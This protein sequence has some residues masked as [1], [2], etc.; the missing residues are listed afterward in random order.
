MIPYGR[1]LIE[2]D[3][4]EA[5]INVLRSDF[6]TQGPKIQEFEAEIA[7]CCNSKY[8]V[9]FNSGTS[10]L[11]AAYF[12]IGLKKRDNFITTP[13]TF[14]A[15][16]NAGL[17]LG[18]RPIFVDVESDTGNVDASRIEER[19]TENTK[20]IVPVHYAGHPANMEVIHNLAEKYDLFVVEDACHAL[21]SKYKQHK[22]GSPRYS[23]MTVLSFHPVKQI[24]TGE[25]GA[26]LTNDEKCYEKL[27]MFRAHGITKEKFLEKPHGDWYYE[28]Q[29]LGY[30]YR[31][32]DIQAALGLSQ[33][34]KLH[35]FI[36]RRR[37]IVKAYERAFDGNPYFDIPVEKGYAF[38]SYHLY[39]I[40]LKQEYASRK[41][42]IFS[43]MKERGLGVQVHYIPVYWQ[44]YYRQM[45]YKMGICPNAEEF[46]R[47]EIS[48][49]LHQSMQD[50][51][52]EFIVDSIL[53]IFRETT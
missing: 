24:T 42:Q 23:D 38:S 22:I 35:R 16:S 43:K 20:L 34:R 25:G 17:Y 51:D 19:I 45:E 32:T 9:A 5:V 30:N 37:E 50:E 53:R 12:A 27:Y 10:A 26:V 15:T 36:E 13:N 3:D 2:E 7:N 41:P 21:G 4:I 6:L 29:L 47:R 40:R 28:M 39:P 46:Y 18:A 14:V 49:P 48:I 52:I 31:M 8:A 33:L 1:Q 44:P 11:H